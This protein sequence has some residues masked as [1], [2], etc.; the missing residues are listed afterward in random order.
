[1]NNRYTVKTAS[2]EVEDVG[3]DYAMVGNGGV[4]EFWTEGRLDVA[5]APHA[6]VF[7]QH[8]EKTDD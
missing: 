2:R 7:A 1:M 5:Y 8:E 3:A 4:L 6:W